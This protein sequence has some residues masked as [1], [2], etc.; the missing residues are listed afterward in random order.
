MA[1]AK[2]ILR[3]VKRAASEAMAAAKCTRTQDGKGKNLLAAAS[4]T[5]IRFAFAAT[6]TA[7]A[8]ALPQP[9]PSASGQGLSL[10]YFSEIRLW[11]DLAI[12]RDLALPRRGWSIAIGAVL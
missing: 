11:P 8:T 12:E 10:I 7:T 6:S 4:L 1:A 5:P 3:L 2:C 9:T